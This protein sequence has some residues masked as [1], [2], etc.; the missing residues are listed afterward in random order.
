MRSRAFEVVK[1]ASNIPLVCW[2]ACGVRP[3]VSFMVST[4]ILYATHA[5]GGRVAKE[6]WEEVSVVRVFDAVEEAEAAVG[7]S[8]AGVLSVDSLADALGVVR[9][10]LGEEYAGVYLAGE[11]ASRVFVAV[12]RPV[13]YVFYLVE[14]DPRFWDAAVRAA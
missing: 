8:F 10:L 1:T 11:T 14:D 12:R 7:R 13:G 6:T 9:A 3:V 2:V 4:V 5:H